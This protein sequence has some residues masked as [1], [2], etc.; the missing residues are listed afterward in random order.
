MGRHVDS[1]DRR[2]KGRVKTRFESL[3]SAGSME[4]TGTLRDVSYSGAQLVGASTKP[5][6]DKQ[7]R[8]YVFIQPVAPFELIGTVVRHTEE[9]FAIAFDDLNEE[10]RRFVDDVAAVVNVPGADS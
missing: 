9:G 1:L 2:R 4:G 7:L 5:E 3:Y 10:V 8:I 6:I